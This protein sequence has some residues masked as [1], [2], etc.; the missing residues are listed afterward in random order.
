[1]MIYDSF[2]LHDTILEGM[3]GRGQ[4]MSLLLIAPHD[5]TVRWQRGI[6]NNWPGPLHGTPVSFKLS[7]TK[8]EVRSWTGSISFSFFFFFCCLTLYL[9]LFLLSAGERPG[10]E[11]K[12]S[13]THWKLG[14]YTHVHFSPFSLAGSCLQ[15][16]HPERGGNKK[17]SLAEQVK[18]FNLLSAVCQ[19][20]QAGPRSPQS[21]CFILLK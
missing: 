11:K 5:G 8:T 10:E 13:Q 14:E 3:Q 21:F 6:M 9:P 16:R 18:L 1:M 12:N 17:K 20:D 4:L 7:D 2:V 19:W 15:E